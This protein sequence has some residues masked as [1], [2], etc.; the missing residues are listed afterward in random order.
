MPVQN[1]IVV[2]RVIAAGLLIASV[3]HADSSAADDDGQTC[4]NSLR[5]D[6]A[7]AA[8]TRAIASG[9][10]TTQNVAT[11]YTSRGIAYLATDQLDRA[12]RD[13]D[14]A[15]RLDPQFAQGARTDPVAVG[16]SRFIF[17]CRAMLFDSRV[18]ATW[19]IKDIRGNVDLQRCVAACMRK[20]SVR[21]TSTQML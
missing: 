7:I 6:V 18:K 1:R 17:C 8:C 4:I 3:L 20:L 5:S 21:S 16:D 2:L 14:Q 15:M 11:L 12:I 19:A 10:Y 13:F 9:Q